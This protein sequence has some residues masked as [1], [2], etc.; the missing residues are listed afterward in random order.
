MRVDTG[1]LFLSVNPCAA[2]TCSDEPIETRTPVT[3]VSCRHRGHRITSPVS[4]SP[5]RELAGLWS[6]DSN[7]SNCTALELAYGDR[8]SPIMPRYGAFAPMLVRNLQKA[9]PVMPTDLPTALLAVHHCLRDMLRHQC[10]ELRGMANMN[11]SFLSGSLYLNVLSTCRDIIKSIAR[12]KAHEA[13]QELFSFITTLMEPA[14]I[15]RVNKEDSRHL[16]AMAA[17]ALANMPAHKNSVLADK[18]QWDTPAQQACI[19]AVLVAISSREAIPVA[20]ELLHHHRQPRVQ[21]AAADAVGRMGTISELSDLMTARKAQSRQVRLAATMAMNRIKY[22]QSNG[23]GRHL[24]R[25]ATTDFIE[26]NEML[27]SIQ[28]STA[29]DLQSIS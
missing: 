25:P 13:H 29:E 3:G 6:S 5:S 24:L 23:I 20:L 11:Y 10:Q 21:A 1:K 18:S 17:H 2:I 15:A 22:R 12:L 4:P 16:T 28:T 7:V 26:P 27:H 8:T 19:I 14:V 9:N